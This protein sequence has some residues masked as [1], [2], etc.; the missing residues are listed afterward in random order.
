[1]EHVFSTMSN[2]CLFHKRNQVEKGFGEKETSKGKRACFGTS[3]GSQEKWQVSQR[4]KVETMGHSGFIIINSS[5][6]CDKELSNEMN[7]RK[8]IN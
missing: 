2:D 3:G 4:A 5:H 8:E 1:M 7:H 6:T